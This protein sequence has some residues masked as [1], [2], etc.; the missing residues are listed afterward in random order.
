MFMFTL[1]IHGFTHKEDIETD[2]KS[3]AKGGFTT[4]VCMANT[5]PIS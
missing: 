3:A 5:N 1:E 2:S 4:V